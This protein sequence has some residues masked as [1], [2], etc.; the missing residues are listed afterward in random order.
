MRLACDT[1]G[2]FTDLIVED[3]EGNLEMYK[4]S[5][6]P[7]DP[8][9]GVINAVRLAAQSSNVSL[10]DYLENV[11][12]FIHGT[13]HAINA[14][15]T[16][17]TAKTAFITTKGHKDILVLKEGGRQD[18]F[19]FSNR[20]PEPYVPRSL[21]F[22]VTERV[23]ADGSISTVLDEQSVLDVCQQLQLLKIEAVAICLL[24]SVVNPVHEKRIGEI[25][26]EQCP[27]IPY[28]LSH[29][30]NQTIRE[31]RRASS[32][33]IDASLKPLMGS[34]LG[35]LS[36]R[37]KDEGFNGRLLVLTSQGG[38]IDANEI[39]SSPI[40]AINSGPSLAPVAGRYFGNKNSDYTDIIVAD[41]GGTTYDVS[42]VRDNQIPL[43]RDAWIGAPFQ[44]FM[45]GFPSVDVQSVGNGGGSIAHVDSGGLLQVGPHSA[46]ADPGP[47]CYGRGGKEPTLSDACAVLGYLDPEYFLGGKI[48]LS[49]NDARQAIA[50]KIATPLGLSIEDAAAAI[51]TLA[52]ENMAQAISDITVSQGI[53]PQRAVLIG[54]GGAAGLNSIFIARR[55]SI[56]RLIIPEVGSALSAAGAL[57]S[58]LAADYRTVEYMNTSEFNFEVANRIIA[59]LAKKADKFLNKM[60]DET[61]EQKVSI[62][63]EARYEQQVWEIEVNLPF[64]EFKSQEDVNT[65][66]EAMHQA[67]ER[68]FSFRDEI[69]TVE[70]IGWLA[71]A[72][73]RVN[74]RLI[75]RMKIEI[76]QTNRGSSRAVYFPTIGE[77]IATVHFFNELVVDQTMQ[78]PA[79]IESP[80]ST[81]VI[82]PQSKFWKDEYGSL[83]IDTQIAGETA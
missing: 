80:F 67:H 43:T 61:F 59:K 30:L 27:G 24:W 21:T 6:T 13:T 41:T 73:C 39:A 56:P 25:I 2:T 23:D 72:S 1:G 11:D 47:V 55:L 62:S 76:P 32:S 14:V 54:G 53:D 22:E 4:A 70:I 26:E 57:M 10:K 60:G 68:I 81:I 58:E 78:G 31:F 7:K 34:Y 51:V 66:I 82:D 8:V 44:G 12:T 15:I 65:F 74:K 71:R 46:G 63:V 42:L 18:P 75:G 36:T 52:T 28:T 49:I 69:A 37:L 50:E 5:T 16:G 19:N 33:V 40:R 9:V 38:M 17:N 83:V 29:A 35:S 20:F 64:S 48:S 3:D 79:I 45:T 77:H